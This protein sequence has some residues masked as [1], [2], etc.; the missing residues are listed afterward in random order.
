MVSD[1]EQEEMKILR[2]VLRYS[3]LI[4]F[5]NESLEFCN[6]TLY[7]CFSPPKY[8]EL[9]KYLNFL[10]KTM[11]ITCHFI[12]IITMYILHFLM[13]TK[14]YFQMIHTRLTQMEVCSTS[15]VGIGS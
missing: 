8:Y 6:M 15:G 10:L 7:I 3:S 5:L 4:I 9:V 14:I 11:K 1:L 12:L 2:E 13:D